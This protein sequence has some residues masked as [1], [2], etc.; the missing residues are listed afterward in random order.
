MHH[1]SKT[2][3]IIPGAKMKTEI[4]LKESPTPICNQSFVRPVKCSSFLQS[5][6]STKTSVSGDLTAMTLLPFLAVCIACGN[7]R[8]STSSLPM[9]Q[10]PSLGILSNAIFHKRVGDWQWG[11]WKPLWQ[12]LGFPFQI[13]KFKIYVSIYY[14]LKPKISPFAQRHWVRQSC[15]LKLKSSPITQWQV[16]Q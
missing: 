9:W 4:C 16:S 13:S 15:W 1:Y 14:N 10:E 8:E 2:E 3:H 5:M 12:N 7:I 6:R 11:F